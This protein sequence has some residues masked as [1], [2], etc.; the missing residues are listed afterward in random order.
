MH[1][2]DAAQVDGVIIAALSSWILESG[3]HQRPALLTKNAAQLRQ[4]L[5]RTLMRLVAQLRKS[6]LLACNNT[7]AQRFV[8]LI[9][10]SLPSPFD[11]GEFPVKRFFQRLTFRW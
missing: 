7:T 6:E 1:I 11:V 10:G 4:D 9:N 3:L 8:C 2:Q 5:V